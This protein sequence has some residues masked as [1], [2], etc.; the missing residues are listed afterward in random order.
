MMGSLRSNYTRGTLR[1]LRTLERCTSSPQTK[2]RWSEPQS[3]PRRISKRRFGSHHPAAD[4]GNRGLDH[5]RAD[6]TA[7]GPGRQPAAG[8]GSPGQRSV[9][10]FPLCRATEGRQAFHFTRGEPLS[11]HQ[12]AHHLFRQVLPSALTRTPLKKKQP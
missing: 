3:T 7:R 10:S 12:R 2:R 8:G 1:P 6:G 11:R 5:L 9:V 4:F